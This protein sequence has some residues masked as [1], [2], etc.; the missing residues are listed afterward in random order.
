[1][2]SR[3]EIKYKRNFGWESRR[4]EGEEGA[5]SFSLSSSINLQHNVQDI[6]FD[7]FAGSIMI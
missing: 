6:L 3:V 4:A 5:S 2:N 1:M 7:E